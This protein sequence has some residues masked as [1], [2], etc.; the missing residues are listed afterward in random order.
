MR[1][2]YEVLG[3]SGNVKCL[4]TWDVRCLEVIPTVGRSQWCSVLRKRNA[5]HFAA[6][7][8]VL[9]VKELSHPKHRRLPR[10]K[11]VSF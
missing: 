11:M 9:H 3:L 2:E 5:Q 6:R 4:S 8:R 10:W 7:E 1:A